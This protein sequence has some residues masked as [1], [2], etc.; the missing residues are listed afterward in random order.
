MNYTILKNYTMTIK[1]FDWT[2][3]F[4]RRNPLFYQRA[5]KTLTWLKSASLFDRKEWEHKRLMQV[6]KKAAKTGYGSIVEK[7]SDFHSWPYLEKEWVRQDPTMFI[8]TPY[9]FTPLFASTASTSG[10]TGEP[11]KLYRS[12]YSVTVEQASIDKLL[13]DRH[14][15]LMK[16]RVAYL[17]GDDI[18]SL[19]NKEPP[20]W[21]M[22]NGG[23]RLSMSSNHLSLQTILHYARALKKFKPQCLMAYPTSLESLCTYLNKMNL[24]VRIPL[25]VTSSEILSPRVRKMAAD[26]LGCEVI[27]Y[28]GQAERVAFAYSYKPSEYYFLP[29]YSHIELIRAGAEGD[30]D[31]YEVIGTSLW[32]LAMPLIRY[33]T[34]DLIK[35]P[36]GM[37]KLELE[38]V[39]YGISPFLEMVGR[40]G[41]YLISPNGAKLT[42]L[43]QIM[44]EVENVKRVQIIQENLTSVR[45][46]VMPDDHFAESNYQEL[47]H[48]TY[49]KLPSSM[50]VKLELVD[51]LKH[52]S[53]GKTPFIIRQWEEKEWN[54]N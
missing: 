41:E 29:G 10:T 25:V 35:L 50:Q 17:R 4:L 6:C 37:S 27:D 9:L 31:L 45:L 48:K 24:Q 11:L 26:T 34:G 16:I 28:Y 30:C 2:N 52:T 21:R 18:K 53:Q 49:L 19:E 42:G 5:F 20:F 1:S 14:I 23:K 39:R 15:E 22:S 44:R 36:K 38:N 13:K 47:I 51:E 3:N 46:L 33:R 40:D 43:N 8:T 7:N 12:P 32:N 54:R